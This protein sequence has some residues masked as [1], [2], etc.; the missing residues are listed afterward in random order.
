MTLII[1]ADFNFLILIIVRH[2][3]CGGRGW[4]LLVQLLLCLITTKIVLIYPGL[5]E[6]DQ[7]G[8][9]VSSEGSLG[10]K[11]TGN[12]DGKEGDRKTN[13]TKL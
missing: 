4:D 6:T 10:I 1:C 13:Q 8:G 12:A 2:D 11:M 5:Q 7:G 9:G 3:N